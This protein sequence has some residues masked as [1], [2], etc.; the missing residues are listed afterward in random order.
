MVKDKTKNQL[1]DELA[2]AHKLIAEF[3]LLD[4]G[5]KKQLNKILKTSAL[6]IKKQRKELE[7]KNIALREIIEQIDI[8]KNKL[9]YDI[10][11]NI[12]NTLLPIL[13]K[14]EIS[15]KSK[16]YY[17]LIRFHL[18]EL[19]S[20]FGRKVAK[21]DYGLTPREVEICNMI[22]G[23]LRSKEVSNLLDLSSETVDKHRKNIRKKVGLSN[24][25]QS[26]FSFLQQF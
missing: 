18:E 16:R 1:I 4:S 25:K 20:S 7:N 11:I 14:L 19:V 12:K 13:S 8:E 22:K 24:K 3:E 2:E 26:L 21:E 17:E 6:Q 15:E 23:G 10:E 5:H 9:R